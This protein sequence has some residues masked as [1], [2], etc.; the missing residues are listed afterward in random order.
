MLPKE[1][2]EKRIE[3]L[4]ELDCLS[5]LT[6]QTVEKQAKIDEQIQHI[7]SQLLLLINERKP[8]AISNY[9][10]IEIP[11]KK[12]KFEMAIEEYAE[13]VL[14]GLSDKAISHKKKCSITTLSRWKSK[15]SIKRANILKSKIS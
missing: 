3:L 15:N 5:A 6:L 9:L 10:T 4:L 13:L 12:P 7:G 11:K 14:S 8:S 2:R 1:I